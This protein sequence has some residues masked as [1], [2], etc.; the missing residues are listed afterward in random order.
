MTETELTIVTLKR[1]FSEMVQ[2]TTLDELARAFS[3]A[4]S[5][6][7]MTMGVTCRADATLVAGP[8]R[9]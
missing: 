6:S 8:R 5:F 1:R 4:N 7:T 3:K 2:F 9:S